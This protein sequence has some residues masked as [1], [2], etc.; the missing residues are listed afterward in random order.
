MPF[1]LSICF[2]NS[3][4]RCSFIQLNSLFTVCLCNLL[5]TNKRNLSFKCGKI[6]TKTKLPNYGLNYYSVHLAK[7]KDVSKMFFSFQA[8]V[9]KKMD[10]ILEIP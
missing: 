10:D 9:I 4:I 3:C 8:V 7:S 1:L 6:N 5:I 2:I